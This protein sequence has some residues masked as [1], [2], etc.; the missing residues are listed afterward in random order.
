MRE[1]ADTTYTAMREAESAAL[2]R[3]LDRLR[4]RVADLE[5]QLA[6]NERRDERRLRSVK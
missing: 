1:S 6:Q 2:R 3:E 4:T 5:A